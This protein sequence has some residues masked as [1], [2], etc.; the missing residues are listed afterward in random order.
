MSFPAVPVAPS[1]AVSWR[2]SLG[3]V[4]FAWALQLLGSE[5]AMVVCG[6]APDG[7]GY[8][9]EISTFGPTT[10]ARLFNGTIRNV[11]IDPAS[12][13]KAESACESSP[14]SC[15][16]IR[17]GGTGGNGLGMKARNP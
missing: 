12:R 13:P 8:L 14:C 1:P 6:T 9:D 4:L 3:L 17:T 16:S 15:P 10:V 7:E 2:L 5:S 11:S